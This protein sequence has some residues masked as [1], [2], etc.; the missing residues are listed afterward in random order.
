MVRRGPRPLPEYVTEAAWEKA[1]EAERQRIRAE[2]R[3]SKAARQGKFSKIF[4]RNKT[5]NLAGHKGT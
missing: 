4:S 3:K 2:N 1:L 5:A